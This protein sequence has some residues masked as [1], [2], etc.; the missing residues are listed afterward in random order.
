MDA[1]LAHTVADAMA[2]QARGLGD[3][4]GWSGAARGDIDQTARFRFENRDVFV[5]YA[6][7]N[8]ADAHAS[9]CNGLCNIG[10]LNAIRVPAPIA[11]GTTDQVSFLALEWLDLVALDSTTNADL[12]RGLAELHRTPQP[13]FGW[14]QDNFIGKTQQPNPQTSDW[15][16]FW[17][18]HR[19]RF[20]LALLGDP[21]L[22]EVG[23][24]LID[25][26]P[27][28]F[29]DGYRPYPSLLHGDLWAGNAAAVKSRPIVYDPACY[30][31]DRETDLA[32]MRLFGGFS[33]ACFEAYQQVLPLASGHKRRI[34]LYQLYHILNHANLF[35]GGYKSQAEQLMQ[36]LIGVT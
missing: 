6:P 26:V 24:V 30:F 8:R 27:A 23:D 9:E 31:G 17:S 1:A 33:Q 18:E 15:V 29:A 20:Q 12:G 19:L 4:R 13:F 22:I 32:M 5:K 14:H 3:L 16:E 10:Q 25:R 34:E 36:R 11:F 35:G 2:S 7:L 28:F 21:R